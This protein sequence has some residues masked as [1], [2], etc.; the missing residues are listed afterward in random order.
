LKESPLKHQQKL[1]VRRKKSL[2]RLL[3]LV[4]VSTAVLVALA[5]WAAMRRN[6][7]VDKHPENLPQNLAQRVSGSTIN[8]SEQG[9]ELFT[10]HAARTLTYNQGS[11]RVLEDVHVVIFGR[12]GDRHDEIQAERCAYDTLTGS[13]ACPGKADLTVP[14]P[15]RG[16]A[17]SGASGRPPLVVHTS[18]VSYNPRKFL[19]RTNAAVRFEYGQDSGAAMGLAYNTQKGW[20]DLNKDV[21]LKLEPKPGSTALAR[22]TA[23]GLH[24]VKQSGRVTLRA[25]V[26]I[27]EVDRYLAGS[28]GILDLDARGRAT[29]ATL[30]GG[31]EGFARSS[32]GTFHGSA[33]TVIASINPETSQLRRLDS[34]GSVR[35]IMQ[36][37]FQERTRSLSAQHVV[38]NFTGQKSRPEAGVASGNV[39][40]TYTSTERGEFSSASSRAPSPG[41]AGERML[42]ANE[43]EFRFRPDGGLE[44]AD[45]VGPGRIRLVPENAFDAR[46]TITAGKFLMAFDSKGR[47]EAIR[48]NAGT[49]M[50]RVPGPGAPRGTAGQ[51]TT[52]DRL[53]AVLDPLTG[54]L[55]TLRQAGNFQFRQAD[56]RASA[57]A[58]Q[59]NAANQMLALEGHPVIWDADSR[60]QAA[61]IKINL[62]ERVAKGWGG[63]QSIYFGHGTPRGTGGGSAFAFPTGP[64]STPLIVRA[65][66]VIAQQASQFAH[67]QGNV[68]AWYGPDIVE[69][70][71]L[72]IYK[73]Q[74]R[75]RSGAGVLSS[76]VQQ[77]VLTSNSGSK[78]S[79]SAQRA[80]QPLTIHA[81]RLIYFQ[82]GKKAIYEGH[83]RADSQNTT[84][85]AD[86]LQVDFSEAPVGG[87]PAVTRVIADGNV[88]AVQLSGRWASGDH[89]V[90]F[91]GSGKIILTGGP[92]VIYDAKH[93]FVTA[94]RLTFF[95][96]DASL[97]AD[98]GPRAPA[99]A[100]YHIAD[101]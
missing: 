25:P 31:V 41:T 37:G 12:N 15:A 57:E 99:V 5:F 38:L 44:W 17:A 97:F 76:F 30:A 55:K 80:E 81:D 24:Y 48:G 86:R 14:S 10:I 20:L 68:R 7:S 28:V 101:Q 2:T 66:E 4:L 42:T 27:S 94:R 93:G 79:P 26:R 89:A 8:R 19:V 67:Y 59:Y 29:L 51:S 72:D 54:T 39:Q 6:A 62:G 32:S 95:T 34:S 91:T 36:Q 84:L 96:H 100:K 60:M 50:L 71:S 65:D 98:G 53:R 82:L 83:V 3:A 16:G 70:P 61:H 63:V 46:Q 85:R 73:R 64:A 49:Q 18:D 92:P 69:S 21:V 13:L 52:G 11:S 58:G 35:L 45:T 56:R 22:V 9:R 33:E 75:V 43:L 87:Q 78:S 23:G 90:Y 74:Q 77:G 40:A 47:L 88:K 1:Y